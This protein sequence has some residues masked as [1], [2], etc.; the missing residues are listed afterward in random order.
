MGCSPM[1]EVNRFGNLWFA[2]SRVPGPLPH[3][4]CIVTSGMCFEKL[5]SE[6]G[7]PLPMLYIQSVM[8][9][10]IP[11]GQRLS[12]FHCKGVL[13]CHRCLSYRLWHYTVGKTSSDMSFYEC[14]RSKQLTHSLCGRKSY[15]KA[16]LKEKLNLLRLVPKPLVPFWL[17]SFVLKAISQQPFEPL[18]S[19]EM[20]YLSFK[21]TLP[22]HFFGRNAF[23]NMW[24]LMCLN[25]KCVC[26]L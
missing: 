13:G 9:F 18:E 15:G 14:W 23:W 20:K 12:L 17:L 3:T 4:H 22:M 2:P 8:H 10:A 16:V 5:R 1:L 6:T 25:K 11:V 24:S 21:T 19:V 26:H 7:H